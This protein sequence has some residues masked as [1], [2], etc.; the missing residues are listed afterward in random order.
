MWHP[1]VSPAIRFATLVA[2]FFMASE[3][4]FAPAGRAGDFLQLLRDQVRTDDDSSGTDS[5]KPSSSSAQHDRR[6]RQQNPSNASNQF[7]DSNGNC[8]DDGLS[9]LYAAGAYL[10]GCVVASPF[11]VPKSLMDD[12]YSNRGYF[13]RFPYERELPGYLMIDPWVP[14]EPRFW[15][16]R[17]RGE[18]G[19]DFDSVSRIGGGLVLD[20]TLRI[21]LDTEFNYRRENLGAGRHDELWTGDANLV[22][23]FAQSEHWAM[24]S[25][26]G[27]NWLADTSDS[28]FGFNFTYAA[29]WFPVRPW[30]V[31]TEMDLGTLGHRSLFHFRV[32]AGVQ[33]HGVE[34]YTGYDYFDVGSFQTNNL[35]GGVRLWF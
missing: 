23:R 12:D 32:T 31:S 1:R 16:G 5:S 25:G 15:G 35:I 34:T 7:C 9:G 29:D 22:F 26:I 13:P 33:W 3:L 21:G 4:V 17:L 6:H 11:W 20:T 2:V 24:R 19:D 27:F 8:N 14:Q 30:I 10:A 18:Y 28:N